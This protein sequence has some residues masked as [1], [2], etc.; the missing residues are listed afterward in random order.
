MSYCFNPNCSNP[1]NSS[2]AKFCQNCGSKLL[3]SSVSNEA[4]SVVYRGIQLIGQGGFGR[5]F[6]VVDESQPLTPYCVIK[7]FF[8]QGSN[9]RKATELFEQEAKQLKIL[10][11]HPQIPTELGYFE[12]D[13]Y[14]YLV[15]EF[16]E[17][18]NLAQ[19]LQKKGVF[20]E[21]KIWFILKDLLPILQFVHE[22]KVIHR[23]I[24]PENIIRRFN[25]KKPIGNLVLVDFGAAKLVTGGMLP[26]TGTMIGSAAYTAPEQLMGKAV[27][28][29]DLYS[30]GVTC[31]HLLTNVP[32]FDLFDSAEGNWVWRDYLKAPVSDELGYI[33]DKMLQGA[34]R[35][36]YNSA[37]AI[38]RHINPKPDYVPV[39]PGLTINPE[40]G[41]KPLPEQPQFIQPSPSIPN[42]SDVSEPAV[43]EEK[44]PELPP[45]R[46]LNKIN[47]ISGILQKRL[48][49]YGIIQVS[50]NQNHINQLTIVLNRDKNRSVKYKE[51]VPIIGYELTY[52][53]INN[54][55][56][57]KLLGR[58]N[59]QNVPE[60]TSLLK[61]DRKTK[62]RNQM[63]R[64][65]NH[66]FLWKLFQLTTRTFWSQQIKK[67][68]FWLDLLMV[69][70]IIFI[71]SDKI[72]ILKPIMALVIAGGFWGVKHQVTHTNTLQ[73][74]Q[75]FATIT[76]LFLM[77]G[78]LNLR[79]WADGMFGIIL[80]GLFISMPIFFS[81]NPS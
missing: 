7:Q 19:E 63:I 14:Q 35:N 69:A 75:L 8:P 53:Q 74:N 79:I 55:E 12:Q 72:I 31:I 70:M 20:T 17:G 32:P 68:E 33:L 41:F 80:A 44:V 27:F 62:I 48:E 29:S 40:T 28:S 71:F 76:T 65:Q 2:D 58:V 1:Q 23:D 59:N 3:L 4:E 36:R 49:P 78:W 77:F 61:L 13:G 67:K 45:P 38:L 34:T 22:N 25:T 50:V 6:L 10:G 30:L 5:T 9:A 39:M 52:C 56:K 60:W 26:K 51:L 43:S 42:I 16:I 73:L 54:L 57:V 37:A 64:F 11:Q 66:K 46:L 24:K 81:R 18:K 15:Q 21:E 47:L